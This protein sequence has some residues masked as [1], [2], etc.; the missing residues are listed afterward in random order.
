LPA[1]PVAGPLHACASTHHHAPSRTITLHPRDHELALRAARAREQTAEFTAAY[2]TRAGIEGTHA[3]GRR[4]SGLR[5]SRYVGQPKTHLQPLLSAVAITLLR[6]GAWLDGTPL[7]PPRQ[8]SFA[9]LMA[10]AA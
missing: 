9:C 6:I 7:A 8:S 2:A 4:V 5:R 1:L 10:Q 3:Q